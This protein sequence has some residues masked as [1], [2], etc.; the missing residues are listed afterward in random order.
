MWW[1]LKG[2]FGYGEA[3]SCG[4]LVLLLLPG[5]LG[6]KHGLDVRKNTALRDGDSLQKLVQ[7]LVIADGE[8]Q[9]ARVDAG[10]LVVTGSIAS[11]LQDLGR[12]VF[13]DGSKVDRGSGT[14]ALGVVA[15]AEHPVDAADW[16]L[17]PSARASALGLCLGFASFATSRHLGCVSS[18]SWAENDNFCQFSTKA[19]HFQV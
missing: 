10:L 8:L 16:E 17:Q 13:H 19:T 11:Q 1:P 14:N 5:L 4:R 9:M 6:Q 3:T 18:R 15:F 2:P 7:L 12:Q